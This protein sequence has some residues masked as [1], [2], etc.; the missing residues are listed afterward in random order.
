[1]VLF[2]SPSVWVGVIMTKFIVSKG[3]EKGLERCMPPDDD[4]RETETGIDEAARGDDQ[5]VPD[6]AQVCFRS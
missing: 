4:K 3:V 1:M 5:E 2:V 6:L